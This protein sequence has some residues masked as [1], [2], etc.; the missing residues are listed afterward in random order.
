MQTLPVIAV[1]GVLGAQVSPLDR[2]FAYG[3]GVFETCKILHGKIPLWQLHKERLLKSCEKL[4]IPVSIDLVEAQF[5]NLI[6]SLAAK[7]TKHAV[8][9]ITV[10]R[11]QGGRGYRAPESVSP[12][13]VIGVFPEASYPHSYFSEGV[14]V[15]LC[16]QRLSCNPGLAGLKHL[17]RLEQI[18][19]RA[20]WQDDAIAEGVLLDTQGNLIEAVFSNIFLIKNDELFTPDLSESGVAGVMRRFI[21]ETLAPQ[22]SLK[23][24]IQKLGLKDLTGADAVFL[25]NSLYG[26]WPVRKLM[27]EQEYCFYPNPIISNLQNLLSKAL[28]SKLV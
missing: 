20:E 8:V 1:N 3:D 2:G 10:T 25:S 26:I 27:S 7:D 4:F 17:N 21:I 15:K 9:K 13:I 5:A 6:A 22:T 18:L 11:G 19:A 24:H 14:T 23:T 16:N 28:T 12:T